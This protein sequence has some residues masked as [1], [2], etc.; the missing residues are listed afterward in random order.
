MSPSLTSKLPLIGE[1]PVP[2]EDEELLTTL[3]PLLLLHQPAVV[4]EELQVLQVILLGKVLHLQPAYSWRGAH[5]NI[6]IKVEY[7]SGGGEEGNAEQGA[8]RLH[9]GLPVKGTL[10]DFLRSLR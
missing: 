1:L 10:E 8:G 2:D 9:R 6:L 4:G 7:Q 5:L 3:V